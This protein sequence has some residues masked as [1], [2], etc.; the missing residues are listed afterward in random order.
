MG[1]G[2]R[3]TDPLWSW[4]PWLQ[5]T[6]WG[7]SLGDLRAE[8]EICAHLGWD[9][10]PPGASVSTPV[11]ESCNHASVMGLLWGLVNRQTSLLLLLPISILVQ[12]CQWGQSVGE[13]TADK[14]REI[15]YVEDSIDTL[16]IPTLKIDRQG[17]C[18]FFGTGYQ[19]RYIFLTNWIFWKTIW[20][21]SIK[22]FR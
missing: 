7:C 19:S 9:P 22:A 17:Y 10:H 5:A 21:F 13:A 8:S 15:M 14:F 20:P 4:A 12:S 6:Q 11:T 18:H 2:R 1:D 3:E 16:L